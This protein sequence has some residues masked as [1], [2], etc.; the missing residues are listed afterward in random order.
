MALPYG[1][2]NMNP[3]A[4]QQQMQ[5]LEQQRAMLQQQMQGGMNMMNMNNMATSGIKGRPVTSIDEVR[6]AMIDLDGSVF[7][8]PAFAAG[9]I[10]TKQIGM[11]GNPIL[12]T[13]TKEELVD[14]TP[15]SKN[16][17]ISAGEFNNAMQNINQK[18]DDL[19]NLLGGNS[20]VSVRSNDANV[21]NGR[22]GKSAKANESDVSAI[23]E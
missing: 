13:Y 17:N 7:V 21:Q 18:I 2:M 5:Q 23:S 9:K 22:R 11:D 20:N 1:N 4:L 15:E 3:F 8:F 10:Y 12:V 14:V 6:G 16:I 19:Y